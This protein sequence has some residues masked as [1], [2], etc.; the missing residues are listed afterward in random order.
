[1]YLLLIAALLLNALVPMEWFLSLGGWTRIVVSCAV[2][3][4]PILFAG[5]IFA[6]SFRDVIS[7]PM[8]LG[9]NI[10]GVILG[11]LSENL[12]MMVGFQYLLLLAI[13]FYA[14]SSVLR[15]RSAMVASA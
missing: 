3:F 10:A 8:A 11:G 13:V 14:L 1:M 6:T 4:L 9:S 7:P 5:I 2:V 15:P 12:S